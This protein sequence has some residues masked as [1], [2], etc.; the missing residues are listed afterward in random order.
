MHKV[1]AVARNTIAQAVRM[2]IVAVVIV[3]LVM[4]LPL[5]SMIMIGDGTVLGK[6]QTFISYGLS[7]TSLLLCLLTI[8]V[9]T[10]TLTN[11]IKRKHIYLI[12]SKPIH[13]FQILCG[14]LLGIV[15][16]NVFLLT[17]FALVI[18]L[19][20]LAIP[21]FSDAEQTEI[22]RAGREFFTARASLTDPIDL[23][24]IKKEVLE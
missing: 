7:L 13:R 21:K 2:K 19:L 15:I 9:S 16:L 4:L 3:L 24:E 22:D 23:D 17:V 5:M 10:Y 6:L 1:W 8:A 14:K 12:I 20:T 11:D 18:Y